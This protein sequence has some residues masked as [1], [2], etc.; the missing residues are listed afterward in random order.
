MKKIIIVT[1]AIFVCLILFFYNKKV[2]NVDNSIANE[3]YIVFNKLNRKR[4]WR[5]PVGYKSNDCVI[6]A[7]ALDKTK[8]I[9]SSGYIVTIIELKATKNSL[10][11]NS[12]LSN[13]NISSC[14]SSGQE[15]KFAENFPVIVSNNFE[16][17]KI[18]QIKTYLD[19]LYSGS[20]V[21]NRYPNPI[22]GKINKFCLYDE[23]DVCVFEFKN[24]SDFKDMYIEYFQKLNSSFI[25]VV[26][27]ST[28]QI[29][30]SIGDIFSDF[31]D[32][33]ISLLKQNKR[34]K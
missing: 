2:F 12:I 14:I 3:H 26:T 30:N 34:A 10:C 28:S 20:F 8:L 16:A 11:L 6:S 32:G 13:E 18:N 15:L 23:Q 25:I 7:F 24:N 22:I 4:I 17:K 9:G 1:F 29:D 31:R 27:S 5:N 33:T 21:T 19:S